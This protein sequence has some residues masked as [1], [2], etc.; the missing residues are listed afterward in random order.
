[1]RLHQWGLLSQYN[2]NCIGYSSVAVIKHYD[3]KLNKVT[4]Q[5]PKIK[6]TVIKSPCRRESLLSLIQFKERACAGEGA[7][8]G[9]WSRKLRGH[10]LSLKKREKTGSRARLCAP[11]PAP[12]DGRV[13]C[14]DMLVNCEPQIWCSPDSAT[15][16]F[17]AILVCVGTLGRP[18]S[19][20]MACGFMSQRPVV[21]WYIPV[22][23]FSVLYFHFWAMEIIVASVELLTS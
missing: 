20:E 21:T 8:A 1:M 7:W 19:D 17:L 22:S 18:Q 11:K 6:N 12:S 13:T 15:H 9:S 16:W 5:N 4:K 23:G 10:N 14:N 3:E 2:F